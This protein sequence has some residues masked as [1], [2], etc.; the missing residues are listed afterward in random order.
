[1][2]RISALAALVLLSASVA[3]G[4]ASAQRAGDLFGG[5]LPQEY[6]NDISNKFDLMRLEEML[7]DPAV[8]EQFVSAEQLEQFFDNALVRVTFYPGGSY[9]SYARQGGEVVRIKLGRKDISPAG[10]TWQSEHWLLRAGDYA[11]PKRP[12][13]LTLT[14]AARGQQVDVRCLNKLELAD[15]AVTFYV[16][17]LNGLRCLGMVDEEALPFDEVVRTADGGAP[18]QAR[19]PGS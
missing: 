14:L 16:G 19:S 6:G 1:M 3:V 18:I 11:A 4:P 10:S 17:P 9:V 13:A 8:L 2:Q 5:D 7:N 12:A 15:Q